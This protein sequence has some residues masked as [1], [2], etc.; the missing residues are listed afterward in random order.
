MRYLEK[1]CVVPERPY[2]I[3][4]RV[5]NVQSFLCSCDLPSQHTTKVWFALSLHRV[6]STRMLYV[7][8]KIS[9]PENNK[10]NC[11][12]YW[13]LFLC[14]AVEHFKLFF[15]S[16]RTPFRKAV[17]IPCCKENVLSWH[18]GRG[19]VNGESVDRLIVSSLMYSQDRQ[20]S[21]QR[22]RNQSAGYRYFIACEK[23]WAA[24][25]KATF[26]KGRLI[27]TRLFEYS[28]DF[29]YWSVSLMFAGLEGSKKERLLK[30]GFF[31]WRFFRHLIHDT[32]KHMD[33]RC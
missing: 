3:S 11:F 31:V 1:D 18:F 14:E 16:S 5:P 29:G 26:F 2:S 7:F 6:I 9:F 21:V 22:F 19:S 28:Y 25:R 17:L 23:S 13:T 33:F 4:A 10:T 24:C 27:H 30:S 15:N 20:R 8:Q 32:W 12:A